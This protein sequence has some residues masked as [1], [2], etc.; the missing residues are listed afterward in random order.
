MIARLRYSYTT[1]RDRAF[2]PSDRHVN[3]IQARFQVI[4]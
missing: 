1:V 3:I 4:F 2:A